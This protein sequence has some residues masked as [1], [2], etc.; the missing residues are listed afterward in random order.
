MNTKKEEVNNIKK[1]FNQK[2][3]KEEIVSALRNFL[4][5]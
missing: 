1:K 3:K 2:E 5:F 4:A